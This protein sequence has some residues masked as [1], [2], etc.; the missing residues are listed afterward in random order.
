[1][2]DIHLNQ[3]VQVVARS[4][5][6]LSFPC[7]NYVQQICLVKPVSKN[8][9]TCK[10]MYKQRIAPEVFPFNGPNC[11]G[12]QFSHTFQLS[13][14]HLAER[15]RNVLSRPVDILQ[16]PNICQ[17]CAYLIA[18]FAH[19]IFFSCYSQVNLFK[20]CFGHAICSRDLFF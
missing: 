16:L 14:I 17:L 3:T 8:S 12:I 2:T 19:L 7:S 4:Q 1:M 20:Y 6:W 15:Q 11:P 10:F 5:K 18:H 13:Q 9:G